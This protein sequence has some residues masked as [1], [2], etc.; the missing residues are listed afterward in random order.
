[1]IC[2]FPKIYFYFT[3]VSNVFDYKMVKVWQLLWLHNLGTFYLIKGE[4]SFIK[5]VF[6]T[7]KKTVKADDFIDTTDRK[8]TQVNYYRFLW[9]TSPTKTEYSKV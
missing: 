9:Q 3:N 6:V 1:M 5:L 7:D 2:I 4:S 8:L